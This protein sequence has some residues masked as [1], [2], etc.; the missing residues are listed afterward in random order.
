[1]NVRTGTRRLYRKAFD[2][3]AVVALAVSLLSSVPGTP[4][5]PVL[6]QDIETESPV[7]ADDPGPRVWLEFPLDG[8]K[9]A[10]QAIEFD[11]HAAD[12]RGVA[13][14]SLLVNG[15]PL[16]DVQGEPLFA[17]SGNRAVRLQRE[18]QPA[19]EGEYIAEARARNTAGTYGEPS[20]VKF[21]VGSCKSVKEP[22]REPTVRP[23]IV[24]TDTPRPSVTKAPQPTMQ[25]TDTPTPTPAAGYDLYV[26]RMDYLPASPAAGDSIQMA[27]MLATDI[28]PPGAAY[29]P[30]SHFRWRQG[31]N[32]PW[33]EE[34]CPDNSQYA[35]CVKNVTFSYAQA[36]SYDFEVQ[37][38][39]RQAV[40]ETDETN[41]TKIWNIVVGQQQAPTPTFT[42]MPGYDLYVR[43]MDFMQ[44]NPVVGDTIE[45]SIML[46]TDI[47]PPGAPYFPASYFR[48]RQGA[49]FPWQEEVCPDNYQYA[50]CVKDV[51]FSYAQPGSYDVEVEADSRGTISEADETN[52]TKSWTI[53]VGQ[54]AQEPPPE[55]PAPETEIY[56]WADPSTIYAGQCA[57][58]YWEVSG[59]EAVYLDGEGVGGSSNREVCPSET[60]AYTLQA[61]TGDGSVEER[62]ELVTVEGG[63]ESPELPP[64]DG[65]I[66]SPEFPPEIPSAQDTTGPVITGVGVRWQDCQAYGY[67]TIIDDS[68]VGWAQ[69]HFNLDGAGWQS[70][71]MSDRGEGY[72]EADYPAQASGAEGYIEYY[73][74]AGDNL[75]YE[76][77]SSAQSLPY[78]CYGSEIPQTETLNW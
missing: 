36:G 68:G 9:L 72:W 6:A 30:A 3:L 71:W 2:V 25:S 4:A 52:N 26:R 50:S 75:G 32:F 74:V 76:N 64:A 18:W 21:C 51:T 13:Q 33:Q 44:T 39:H 73:V 69:F 35:S 43:R 40:A 8:Q 15:E 24:A 7:E 28:A 37:A 10:F 27:I 48:W 23:L 20:Y 41:N 49:N 17:G 19:E 65:G 45:L 78:E 11:V 55:P 12:P 5:A 42:P 16:P 58:L 47:A 60:T 46:A 59:V 57:T 62:Q 22:T 1:M 70:L 34:T 53:T 67:A 54:A 77:E 61:V 66:G 63:I 38:D 56:F 31:A 14:V 29:F